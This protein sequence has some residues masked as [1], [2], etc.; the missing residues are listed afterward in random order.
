[1]NDFTYE[2]FGANTYLVYTLAKNEI[3]DTTSLGMLTNNEIPGLAS[4]MFM[5]RNDDRYIK[6]KVSSKIPVSQFF[7]GQ[8]NRK[9]LLSVFHGIADA[10]LSAEEYMIDV[11]TLA[12]D[13]NYIYVD[14]STFEIVLICLPVSEK[15]Q[16]K[17]DL[18]MFFRNV[19]FGI[20]F[21][22]TENCEY[23]TEIIN[24]LN[25]ITPFTMEYFK[26][27]LEELMEIP[28]KPGEEPSVE[29]I[30]TGAKHTDSKKAGVW[31]PQQEE[32]K[33]PEEP[34]Q[35]RLEE[36]EFRKATFEQPPIADTVSNQAV[37]VEAKKRMSMLYLLQHYNKENAAIYKAQKTQ[38]NIKT[39]SQ[40]KK[41]TAVQ[42]E[43]NI[44]QPEG[45]LIPGHGNA[46]FSNSHGAGCPTQKT[47]SRHPIDRGLKN[48][49][50]DFGDTVYVNRADESIESTETT[51][52]GQNT[53]SK[54]QINPHLIRKKNN[55][56]IPID[57]PIFRLGRNHEFNDYVVDG[58]GYVG[59]SHCHII[60][61]GGEYFI[62]D[63]NSKNHTYVDE[64]MIPSGSEFKLIHGQSIKLADEEFEF[65][66]F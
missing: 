6:Y 27:L 33:I 34:Q 44:G 56:R 42:K 19:M 23:V 57:K 15:V 32:R 7:I 49:E 11:K 38:K 45:I 31:L 25:G 65:R 41:P 43:K 48:L 40:K 37:S 8:V 21:D 13:L 35:E 16:I 66:L 39:A 55:E 58:N 53:S 59:N 36:V 62:E 2:N 30:T 4:T 26:E 9:K 18:G 24:Y 28:V 51:M 29:A 5:Q 60:A 52:M 46:E 47:D 3:V 14:V 1:M 50:A 17:I 22:K 54:Q 20:Q 61:K 12:M 63:D 10:V 64:A